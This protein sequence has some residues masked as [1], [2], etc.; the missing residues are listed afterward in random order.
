MGN[1]GSAAHHAAIAARSE[2]KRKGPEFDLERH[3]AARRASSYS[4]ASSYFAESVG[5]MVA[6]VT[7]GSDRAS[8][9]PW[10]VW[11]ITLES[12]RAIIWAV[13]KSVSAN[14]TTTDPSS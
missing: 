2:C 3:D 6:S 4:R 5:S 10:L 11:R 1:H 8:R 12:R 13:R 7:T 14:T 9:L